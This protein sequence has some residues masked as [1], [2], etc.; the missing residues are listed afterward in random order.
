MNGYRADLYKHLLSAGANVDM[1]GAQRSGNFPKPNN[2]GWSGYTINQISAKADKALTLKPN[3]VLLMAGTNDHGFGAMMGQD[4]KTA[5]SRLEA[6]IDK[7][8]NA[9][10]EAAVLVASLTP[11]N[12]NS[13]DAFNKQVPGIVEARASRGKKV[14]FV[15]MSAVSK[16][17]LAD[18]VHPNDRGY[19]KMADAWFR[20]IEG[21]AAKGW[22]KDPAH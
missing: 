1:V 12:G 21:V 20:S 14:A 6:L 16:S 2:E 9:V 11:L 8:V 4:P 5:P 22:I 7:I 18:G 19:T 15:D 13:V 17:D 3:V 10:P